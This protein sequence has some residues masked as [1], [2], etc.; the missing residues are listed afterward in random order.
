G[1]CRA[2]GRAMRTVLMVSEKPSLA[3]SI[4]EILSGRQAHSRKGFNNACSVH[5]W[6]GSFRSEPVSFRMTSVCGHVMSLD[7]LPKYNN[8][9]R[10]DPAELFI[11]ET[12]KKEASPGLK[13]P[14][15]LA[16]EARGCDVLVL[17]LDCD[18]EGENICFEVIE[19]VSEAMRL[20]P[21]NTYRA[22]F[23]AITSQ[24]I[25]HAMQNLGRPN[26]KEA[27]S[28]DARQ[29]LDLRIGCAFT[30]FQT[31]FFQGKYGNLDS[32]CIS[33]GPCQTPTLGFCVTRH[34][35]IQSFKPETFWRLNVQIQA[36][37][38]A[39][40]NGDSDRGPKQLV[41]LEWRRVRVFE[42]EIAQ[43]FFN[44][45]KSAKVAVVTDVRKQEKSK[46]RPQALNTV[47]ML[48]TASSGLG[49]GPQQTMAVAERLYT[50]GYISYPRTETTSYP[51]SFDLRGPVNQLRDC[52][53]WRELAQAAISAGLTKPRKGADVGDHPPI[54]PT[55]A[56]GQNELS[57]DAWRLYEMVV[58]HYLATLL[59]DAKY[60]LTTVSLTVGPE[61]FSCSG[62]RLL[63]PGFTQAQPWLAV[64]ETAALGTRKPGQE[65]PITEAGIGEGQTGPPDYLTESELI[66]LME[67][68]GIGTDASIPVHIQ[69]I[70]E[71]NYVQ[72]LPGR[73]LMPTELGIV[74]VHGYE[75]ID[76]ELA[77]PQMRS[78]VEEQLNLIARGQA[79]YKAVL[80]HALDIFSA[81]FRYFVE[82]ISAMDDLFEVS[83][84]PLCESG[85]PLSRCGKCKRYM[86]LV[87]TRPQRLH[88]S[89]CNDT[90]NLPQMG[91]IRQY[92]ELKCPLD[93]FELV[94]WTQGTNSKSF[95]LCPY[96]YAN[97]PF[98][99]MKKGSGCNQ[100]SHPTCPQSV[101]SNGID[102]CAACQSG[103][104]VVDSTAPPKFKVLC[105][106]CDVGL[107][108][109]NCVT[110]LAVLPD[111][112]SRCNAN[113]VRLFSNQKQSGSSEPQGYLTGCIFCDNDLAGLFETKDI[114]FRRGQP[115]GRRG[116]GR[117]RGRGG[118]GRGGGRGRGG[119]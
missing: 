115:G 31:K 99:D 26:E 83:F 119:H 12:Q 14:A 91:S 78:A 6:R 93:D 90:Y 82:H 64:Q 117:G 84:D 53:D 67:K 56:V 49:M 59:P 92:K 1:R 32:N 16:R 11:A 114:R 75:K 104:L 79:D 116:R 111:Q 2:P 47:E 44:T 85:K 18:K 74:L 46:P 58:R 50:Q 7:F 40:P 55:R 10:C 86:K 60:E 71:R 96:C 36:G 34:D 39:A 69:N 43:F 28:V 103:V 13:M 45:I 3:S 112:C 80:K 94:L 61:E 76:K 89:H 4:S 73:K 54:T 15:F 41:P 88:C 8:W 68:H 113:R 87:A 110:K 105:N 77:L 20:T 98:E 57:G 19:A 38:E 37:G 70:M 118:G 51:D 27:I 5:E 109:D 25:N 29:E 65:F 81:K 30:R 48:R 33:Y 17:W 101:Q 23:S 63:D 42:R 66:S 108:V 72:L 97:P 35:R 95:P 24:E 21:Q 52:P 22:K 62:T 100:C 102:G 107:K 9:D 106:Q